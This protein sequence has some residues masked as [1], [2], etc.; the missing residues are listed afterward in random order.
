MEKLESLILNTSVRDV[1]VYRKGTSVVCMQIPHP[2]TSVMAVARLTCPNVRLRR[3]DEYGWD[4][5]SR[6]RAYNICLPK[7]QPTIEVYV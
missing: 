3:R 5:R 4:S 6:R 1:N 2:I 7:N